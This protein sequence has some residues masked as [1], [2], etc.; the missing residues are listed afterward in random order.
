[1]AAIN[2]SGRHAYVIGIAGSL[3]RPT[4]K[5]VFLKRQTVYKQMAEFLYLVLMLSA[6]C[7][8]ECRI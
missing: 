6:N 5:A 7:F 8:I 4:V 2:G 1:M 3:V